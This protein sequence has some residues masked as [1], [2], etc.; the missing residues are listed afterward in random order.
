MKALN[1]LVR[2][3][4]VALLAS[5]CE[6]QIGTYDGDAS[7]FDDDEEDAG[8]EPTAT[9]K[10]TAKPTATA[11]P[12]PSEDAG[13]TPDAGAQPDT[14][15][16]PTQATASSAPVATTA[17][18]PSASMMPDP[19]S[20]LCAAPEAEDAC[21]Q[22]LKTNCDAERTACCGENC[23]D[24]WPEVQQCMAMIPDQGDALAAQENLDTCIGSLDPN[25]DSHAF[26]MDEQF[27]LLL[28]C[29][30]STYSGP[31]DGSHLPGDGTC[32][33][34]CYGVITLMEE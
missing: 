27:Q 2:I 9:A 13:E 15:T 5:G 19:A 34:E 21:D 32:T 3:A 18:A 11:A 25:G 1:P 23:E 6:F 33:Y 29:V 24:I 20:Y 14:G 12:E 31:D 8:S 7:F 10:P 28:S 26:D 17:A 4:A 30:N 22:C 16:E